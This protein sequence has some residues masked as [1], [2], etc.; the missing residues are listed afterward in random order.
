MAITAPAAGSNIVVNTTVTITATADDSDGSVTN[1]EFF[2]NASSIGT[3]TTNP[4]TIS[5]TPTQ[6]EAVQLTA[7]ATD[8]DNA[9]A[10]ADPVDVVVITDGGSDNTPPSVT[11]TAPGDGSTN[12][13]DPLTI[14]ADAT[15]NVG[16]EGVQFQLDGEDI[17]PED[18]VAPF[19]VPLPDADLYTSGIHVIRARARDAAGNL[20]DW[21][22]STVTF[23]GNV[24]FPQGFSRTDFV[25]GL[26]LTTTMAFAPDGRLFIALQNGDLRVV[27]KTVKDGCGA[28]HVTKQFAPVF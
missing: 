4:Y 5:W 24:N 23:G 1:V 9:T 8:D 3:A 19:E 25:D 18:T 28:G 26:P 15:D 27:E 11:I 14:T 2:A 17:G 6:V 13:F 20:S 21:A 7:R 12:L 22:V 10:D 16:V